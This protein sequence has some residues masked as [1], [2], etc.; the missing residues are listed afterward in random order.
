[1]SSSYQSATSMRDKPSTLQTIEIRVER[2]MGY[3]VGIES[4]KV[5]P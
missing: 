5:K 1:M 4:A 2:I 3:G